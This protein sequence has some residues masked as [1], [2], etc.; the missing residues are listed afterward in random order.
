MLITLILAK[1]FLL[2]LTQCNLSWKHFDVD[3]EELIALLNDVLNDLMMVQ[4]HEEMK[5]TVTTVSQDNAAFNIVDA[6][7]KNESNNSESSKLNLRQYLQH[8]L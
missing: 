5:S 4:R 3:S 6:C 7:K 1:S 2:E 8:Y